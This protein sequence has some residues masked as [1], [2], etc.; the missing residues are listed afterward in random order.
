MT[1]A[2]MEGIRTSLGGITLAEEELQTLA[3]ALTFRHPSVLRWRRGAAPAEFPSPL[4]PVPWY[5][6]AFR[7]TDSQLRPSHSLQ[8]AAADFYLQDAGSLLA[9]AACDADRSIPWWYPADRSP[10]VCDLC[11][12]PGG[13][14]SALAEMIGDDGFLLA[15]EPIRS[16]VPAL[17]HNL[18]RTGSDRYAITTF[19]P[20]RLAE[21]LPAVF[22]MVLVDAPCSGQ[23]LLSRGRQTAAALSQRQIDHSAARQR[24]ILGSAVRLLRPGGMLVYSTC[25]FAEAENESQVRWL[26]ST[27]GMQPVSVS[28]MSPYASPAAEGCY[29]LW[30]H[31]HGTAGSFAA[32]LLRGAA[33]P[34]HDDAEPSQGELG[35]QRPK[36]RGK[37]AQAAGRTRG[38]ATKETTIDQVQLQAWFRDLERVDIASREATVIGWPDDVPDW[39]DRLAATGPE[40]AYRTGRTW[41]PAHAA[42]VRRIPRAVSSQVTEVDEATARQFL[43]GEP[44]RSTDRGWF[45]VSWQGRPL[46][47][48]KGDGSM[49]KNHLPTAARMA[50]NED[51]L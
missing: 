51:Q 40:L 13:K 19:D 34:S 12:A 20:R 11:A 21:Q 31:R 28:R 46:G 32:T 49:A 22:D 35:G 25:T 17:A 27:H 14:A 30:P 4:Q 24:R 1:G 50:C 7:S 45:V 47:W 3:S 26:A 36:R 16:R 8:F 43:T 5:D 29:R 9:L 10:L 2:V 38:R 37:S 44:L 33:D 48:A 18:A 41:K 6:L 23:A 42:A 15:N 39:V